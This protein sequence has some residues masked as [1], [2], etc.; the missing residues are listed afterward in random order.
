[1][2]GFMAVNN[3]YKVNRVYYHDHVF[4]HHVNNYDLETL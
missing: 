2:V 3:L 4:I 1:M